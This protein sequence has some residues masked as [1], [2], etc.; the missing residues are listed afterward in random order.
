MPVFPFAETEFFY[1]A[2]NAR[3]TFVKDGAGHATSLV[4]QVNGKNIPAKKIK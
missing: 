3:I 2:I 4:F 1:K